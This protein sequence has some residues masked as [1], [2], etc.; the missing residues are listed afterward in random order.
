[1][2]EEEVRRK[3]ENNEFRQALM[4]APLWKYFALKDRK[5]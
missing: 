2:T 3:L 5:K 1:M 4:V